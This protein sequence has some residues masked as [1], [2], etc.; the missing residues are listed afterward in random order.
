MELLVRTADFDGKSLLSGG[1]GKVNVQLGLSIADKLTIKVSDISVPKLFRTGAANA[2]N[3]WIAADITRT[4]AHNNQVTFND[5]IVDKHN[6]S[7]DAALTNGELLAAIMATRADNAS[8][9][10]LATKSLLIAAFIDP[11]L[12]A[13][14]GIAA[15]VNN[16]A[17]TT[18]A[19]AALINGF[20]AGNDTAT[21]V[22]AVNAA[23]NGAANANNAA[24]GNAAGVLVNASFAL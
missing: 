4:T 16:A 18:A 12:Q 2:I 19:T 1:A 17:I 11:A 24:I 21:I 22:A 23:A 8:F 15:D 3:D 10:R 6:F 14:V 7:Q 9:A 5:A 20:E 13:D